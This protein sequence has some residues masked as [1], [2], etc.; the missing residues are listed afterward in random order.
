MRERIIYYATV[1][2]AILYIFAGN[3][4]ATENL[5]SYDG[6]NHK[7][8]I[9]AAVTEI[10]D[11]TSAEQQ[12]GGVQYPAGVNI[13]FNAKILSGVDKGITI[14]ALQNHDPLSPMQI[15]E[16]E[17]GDKILLEKTPYEESTIEWILVEYLRSDAVFILG[18]VFAILL[19]LFGRMK[20][21]NT[22]LSL[23]FTCLAIFLVFIPSVL[24]G[25][26][27][28]FWSALTC[29]FIVV[30]TLIL[31]NGAN[32]KSLAAGIGC[33]GGVLV[34]SGITMIMDSIIKLTGLIDD[35][36]VYL[37]LLNEDKPI[38]LKA[39]VFG[40]I[41][42][43]AIGA[44]MDVSMDIAASLSEVAYKAGNPGLPL[45]FKS[46]ITIGRDIVGTMAS[47]LILAY[48]GSSLTIVLLIS[49]Y[50]DSLIYI[51]NR[52]MII[53]EILQALVGSF[54]ILF[55]IPFTS[56]MCGLMYS[57]RKY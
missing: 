21:F 16:V 42:I 35:E 39:V 7:E 41:L 10:I 29:G 44:I 20:G 23:V 37:F 4:I 25:L 14:T 50:N 2:L 27:I 11:R 15:R 24:S 54:G 38:D 17:V 6:A 49:A 26:D 52:E 31:V 53:T 43:G 19:L 30:V 9:K 8:Y 28:Y 22:I 1:A 55:A 18:I 57:K 48:I 13:R 3:R 12:I 56:L 40:A 34:A 36:S 45:L 33:A 47:T 32:S 46:G 51:L 5:R